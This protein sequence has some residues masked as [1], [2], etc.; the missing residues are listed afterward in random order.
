MPTFIFHGVFPEGPIRDRRNEFIQLMRNRPILSSMDHTLNF[1][2]NAEG[3]PSL[4]FLTSTSPEE[5]L[6]NINNILLSDFDEFLGD[7]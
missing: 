6:V 4:F 1:S 3:N 2:N 5:D 7:G